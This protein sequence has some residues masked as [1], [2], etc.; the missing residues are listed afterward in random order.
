[1]KYASAALTG[2]VGTAAFHRLGGDKLLSEELPKFGRLA[3]TV[4]SDVSDM[5]LKDYN[6]ENIGGLFKRHLLDD[7]STWNEIRQNASTSLNKIDIAGNNAIAA[8]S[9]LKEVQFN[10]DSNLKKIFNTKYAD[11][12][13]NS[14]DRKYSFDDKSFKEEMDKLIRHAVEHDDLHGYEEKAGQTTLNNSLIEKY[15]NPE[16]LG[17]HKDEF[18]NDL[19]EATDKTKMNEAFK[20]YKESHKSSNS[21]DFIENVEK[22]FTAK[23][24][25]ETFGTSN[26]SF[27][28][29]VIKNSRAMTLGDY[30][31]NLDKFDNQTITVNNDVTLNVKDIIQEAIAKDES[32]RDVVIDPNTLRIGLDNNEIINYKDFNEYTKKIS[33]EFA[34]TLPGK[35]LKTTD[36]LSMKEPSAFN[37]FIKGRSAPLINGEKRLDDNYVQILNKF[38]K[39]TDD[40]SLVHMSDMDDMYTMSS[41][42]GTMPRMLNKMFGLGSERIPTNKYNRFFD[43]GN[44]NESSF[45]DSLTKRRGFLGRF[46]RN[47]FGGEQ[48]NIIDRMFNAE[49][50]GTNPVEYRDN[51]KDVSRALSHIVKVPDAKTLSKM[52]NFITDSVSKDMLR[53]MQ[54]ED[55]EEVLRLLSKHVKN[56]NNEDLRSLITIGQKD[57]QKASQILSIKNN[58]LS[59]EKEILKYDK[60]LKIQA[61]KEL[62]LNEIKDNRTG[63]LDNNNILLTLKRAGITGHSFENAKNIAYWGTIQK[64][65]M[66]FDNDNNLRNLEKIREYNQNIL[67]LLTGKNNY[68]TS[69][70]YEYNEDLRK[71]IIKIKDNYTELTTKDINRKINRQIRSAEVN[72]DS[73]IMRKAYTVDS[74]T[75]DIIK[76]INDSTKLKADTRRF[77]MQF[78]AGKNSPEYVTTYTMAPYF[79]TERLLEPFGK[80][81]LNFS[82]ANMGNVGDQWKA[83]LT[84]RVLPA[85]LGI[86][87][88]SYLNFETKNFTGTSMTGALAQGVANVDLGIRKLADITGI[89]HLLKS[90]RAVDPL[91]QYWFGD[92]Y[93]DYDERKDYY[94]NGYDAVRKGRW[95]AFGSASEFR[96]GKISYFEPNFVK[97]ANSDWYDI[98]LYGSVDNKWKHSWI[99]T[100]RHPLSPIRR[101]F[102]PYWLERMHYNDRPYLQTAPMFS[103]G[104]PWGVVLNPTIGQ[105]I[106]PIRRMHRDETRRGLTDPRTLIEERNEIIK[107][108][109]IDKRKL[110]MI[111]ISQ[112][113]ITNVSYTPAALAD[114]GN[115][116][117][118]LKAG[119][120][121]IQSV[122]Y[123][124]VGY[125]E[126][127]ADIGKFDYNTL[128][129]DSI[130]TGN[131][132]FGSS[133]KNINSYKTQKNIGSNLLY[134]FESTGIGSFISNGIGKFLSP[135]DIIEKQN[136]VTL[137]NANSKNGATIDKVNLATM[138]FKYASQRL[139]TQEDESDLKL[140][141]SNYDFINDV[142]FSG[143][144]IM[145]MY[146]FLGGLLGNKQR[147]VR[148][149]NA[150]RMISFKG[151][152]WDA[153]I[154]GLGGGIMEISRRFFPHEEHD[155]I[156][157]NP[158]RN[159][160]PNWM[161]ERFKTGDPYRKVS[162]G[163]MRLPGL[164]YESIH[165][166]HPDAY[167]KYGALDRMGIL[168]DIAPWSDEYKIW[169]QIAQSEVTDPKG[170]KEIKDIKKRVQEQSTSHQFFNYKFLGQASKIKK[171][172]IESASG[173]TFTATSG[174]QYK[175]AGVKLAKGI[176]I[177]D[178]LKQ[179]TEVRVEYLKKDKGIEGTINAAVYID[180]ENLNKKLVNSGQA[181]GDTSTSMGAKA[182]TGQIGQ[183]Y[184]SVMEA[185]THAPIPFVHNKL[186]RIDTPL[187]SYK[188]ERVY[189]TP[190]STWEHPIR[191]FIKPAFQKS[192]ARGPL[193]QGIALSSWILA[194]NIWR[195]SEKVSNALSFMG[196]H[197][198]ESQ[199]NKTA[200]IIMNALNPGA[201][202]GSMMAAIPKGLMNEESIFSE[203]FS[204]SIFKIGVEDGAGRL[205]A[206][207]GATVMLAGY[208]LSRTSNPIKSTAIFSLAGVALSNQ[209]KT[210]KFT[211]E[212]GAIV[213]A[214]VGLFA[215]ALR[216]PRLNKNKMFG[217]YVPKDTRKRWDIDEYYDR[218]DY[219]KYMGLYNK[220]ARKARLWEHTNIKKILESVEQTQKNNSKKIDRINNR[221]NKV[222]NSKLED[223]RKQEII[224][225]LKSQ[226]YTM[227][228]TQQIFR[229]GKYT[230]AAIAYKQAAESTIYGLSEN[231]TSQQVMRAIPKSDKDFFMEFAKEKNKKKQ[232]EILKYVSP[233]QRRALEIAWGRKKIEKLEDNSTYF[234]NHLLPG[235]FWSGWNP[236]VNTEN[237]KIKTIENEGML[238]SDFGIYD[239]QKDDPSVIS[240][241][242]VKNFDKSNGSG[243]LGLQSKLQGILQGAGLIGVKVTVGPTSASGIEVF[244]NITNAAKITE[245]KVRQGINKV[246]GTRLFY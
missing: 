60:M 5:R 244:A 156:N 22:E 9:R 37:Y 240:A 198:T 157:I 101:A 162:K 66:V 190:Y 171:E 207:I 153:N 208:G 167:G 168:A 63:I 29:T 61:F 234:R 229:G 216:N 118:T 150:G 206:R 174:Q 59:N 158:I 104:T 102:D 191:G 17:E 30:V 201:F 187:E 217:I 211:S 24:L 28:D 85:A 53:A 195:N 108:K 161:P 20:D 40:N 117:F 185:I 237:V 210:E 75:K 77:A 70:S 109:A 218:I 232:D 35:I 47:T 84:K 69:N 183:L 38:Y 184:G 124:G 160:M 51:L 163:E 219:L 235:V 231:A 148:P 159:T 99:P 96:G 111:K 32:F 3:K 126:S 199:I 224:N 54:S 225:N 192:F 21:N 142:L 50:A 79:L 93:Q 127:L 230:R 106:K 209:L 141:N 78:V 133:S 16:K 72:N 182:L 186:M 164:G 146:G 11:E 179:G 12:V 151:R 194:E 135:L 155:W 181:T 136:K 120:G 236:R 43:V 92:D 145:G 89:T 193:G 123:N 233:Y 18:F 116:V 86:T 246:V 180:G 41:K 221:I 132:S 55:Q 173:T 44:T 107:Q 100:P 226:L 56:Y 6:A 90:E 203:L 27:F 2:I 128:D 147:R 177:N 73:I 140:T 205:G 223:T 112:N 188:N 87:A 238:L 80:F 46:A 202:A 243:A 68:S 172:T 122:N 137:A 138:P 189:G 34:G 130:G 239:S 144:D 74:F 222:S 152:F 169:R 52:E 58:R 10:A 57:R 23:N 7:N 105:M 149:D 103:Q 88:L 134:V 1:M 139:E 83:I 170:K 81:G 97:R 119:N 110:N 204:T 76:D 91:T 19:I 39:V 31:D 82:S 67:K 125:T 62:L 95:W 212:Q 197:A 241:P 228:E 45:I 98:G 42:H 49:F 220:A 113:G 178:Y 200:S 25:G 215:S 14:I 213:G 114:N 115:V 94:E 154:G 129:G 121:R 196:L 36:F 71:S 175:L 176:D 165:K 64:A 227:Q 33:R 4:L 48:Y 143:K 8:L 131:S 15:I 245:Y 13:I 166:L 65:G 242:S 26:D 214:T